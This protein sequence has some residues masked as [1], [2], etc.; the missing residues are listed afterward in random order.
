MSYLSI[1]DI[2]SVT[3]QYTK[4]QRKILK[5]LNASSLYSQKFYIGCCVT[6]LIRLKSP[7]TV[8]S[9]N[10]IPT[11]LRDACGQPIFNIERFTTELTNGQLH[12]YP[13]PIALDNKTNPMDEPCMHKHQSS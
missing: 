3:C 8:K 7:Q 12:K 4:L 10:I 11:V 6:T 13:I 9:S 5:I 1:D 2:I